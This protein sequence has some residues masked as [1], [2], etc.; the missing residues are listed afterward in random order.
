[1]VAEGKSKATEMLAEAKY[2]LAQISMEQGKTFTPSNIN[3]IMVQHPLYHET[4]LTP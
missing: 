1:M 4:I 3:L 2:S